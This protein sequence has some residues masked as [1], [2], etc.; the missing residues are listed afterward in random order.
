MI[1]V[2]DRVEYTGQADGTH[3]QN[4]LGKRGYVKRFIP[5]N[6]T[7]AFVIFDNTAGVEVLCLRDNLTPE[8][9]LISKP[10]E[11]NVVN[12]VHAEEV[13]VTIRGKRIATIEY[14]GTTNYL[15]EVT[16]TNGFPAILLVP[17]KCL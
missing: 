8:R 1:H 14:F 2:N 10:K 9:D 11:S 16:Q 6:T 3:N 7:S 15:V 17:A 12:H 4:L 13:E 5:D